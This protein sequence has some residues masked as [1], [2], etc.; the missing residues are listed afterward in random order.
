MRLLDV[1][2]V[3]SSTSMSFIISLVD[4]FVRDRNFV[5]RYS[6][7]LIFGFVDF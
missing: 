3:Y 4:I 6:F 5:S 1:V 7:T 2:S